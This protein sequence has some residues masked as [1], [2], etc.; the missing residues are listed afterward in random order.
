MADILGEAIYNYFHT[1]SKHKLWIHNRYGEKEEMPIDT[2]FRNEDDMPD[3]EWLALES[4]TG[5]VLDVGA[6]A[7]SHALALQQRDMNVTALDISPLATQVMR[8]RGVKKALCEDIYQYHEQQFDTILLLMNGIGLAGSLEG[9]KS[10]LLHLK[11]LL[12]SGGQLLFDSSDIA[13]L[14]EEDFPETGYY[15]E[16]DYQYEYQGKQGEWFKWL[17]VDEKTLASITFD[18]GFNQEVLLEDEFGQYLVRLT[19][20]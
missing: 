17:Y 3:L 8:E 14:Y 7:G 10:L 2:Y 12:K 16:L 1:R 11:S 15:G 13:Y 19:V 9:L 18:L 5:A 20:S 4:C 6:G